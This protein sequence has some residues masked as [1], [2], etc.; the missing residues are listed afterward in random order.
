MMLM[1][2]LL[3]KN[4]SIPQLAG[5]VFAG[6]IGLS[7]IL[8]GIQFYADTKPLYSSN[9]SFLKPDFLV[10]NKKV[11]TLSNFSLISNT[12]SEK[13][14]D[15]IKQQPF[16][17]KI[18]FFTSSKFGIRASVSSSTFRRFYTEMF[19]ESVPDDF[20]DVQN[21]NWTWSDEH[22]NIP[23][24]IPRTYLTLY[25]FGFAQSQ[26]L[27]QVS[28]NLVEKIKL[29]VTAYGNGKSKNFDAHI[30]GFSDKLNTI[31]VP[32]SFLKWANVE[33]GSENEKTSMPSRILVE[34]YN[35]SDPLIAKYFG[36]K[37][38]EIAD[39]RGNTGKAAYFL[40]LVIITVLVIGLIIT[41]LAVSLMLLSISLL[42]YKNREKLENMILLGYSR[43]TVAKPYQ[44]LGLLLTVCIFALAFVIVLILRNFYIA[45]ISVLFDNAN[46]A[47]SLIFTFSSGFAI[48]SVICL[49]NALWIRKK[50]NE[51]AK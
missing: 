20:I 36:E 2:K 37:N 11:S 43:S 34:I 17:K 3:R 22:S 30:A 44:I 31:L 32:E 14:V 13:D 1:W 38:Y 39:Y 46:I 23:I 42:I 25:N 8:F 40:R 35:L 19:F 6:F 12:F 45:K 4:L 48:L 27:P 29:T 28:E 51:T 21:E 24:I 49:I 7:I 33:Y 26:G 15:D 5:Y 50:V 47:S 18:G 41:L 16:V 10:I 9:D